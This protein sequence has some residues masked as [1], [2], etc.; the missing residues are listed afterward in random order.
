MFDLQNKV[1]FANVAGE[2]L[3]VKPFAACQLDQS[4]V[5]FNQKS[6]NF[7]LIFYSFWAK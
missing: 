1:V 6:L 7:V 2:K 3:H 5:Y 4:E